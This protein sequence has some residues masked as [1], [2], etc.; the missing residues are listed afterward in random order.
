VPE[1][2]IELYD[3]QRLEQ[4]PRYVRAVGIR[5]GRAAVNFEKDLVKAGELGGELEVVLVRLA[6]YQEKAHKQ[7]NKIVSA[8]VYPIVIVSMAFIITTPP[9]TTVSRIKALM[10]AS[11]VAKSCMRSVSPAAWLTITS[12]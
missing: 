1:N 9:T 11:S 6:E 7:K 2:F 12:G 8:M 3:L 10:T 4:I 5:A